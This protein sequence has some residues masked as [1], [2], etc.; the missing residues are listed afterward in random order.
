MRIEATYDLVIELVPGET[1]EESVLLLHS[2]SEEDD[3][4]VI[5][6]MPDEIEP[7]REA[8]AEAA[9]KLAAMGPAKSK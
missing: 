2:M 1:P 6:I 8:L 7:L 3:E 5:V 9:T 4:Q